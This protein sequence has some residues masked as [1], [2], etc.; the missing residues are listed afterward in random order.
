MSE[1][2]RFARKL[3]PSF[4]SVK[5]LNRP[6]KG[7][8]K[9]QDDFD[10]VRIE[11]VN[12]LNKSINPIK[13]L[14]K[15]K[16]KNITIQDSN[17]KP[18]PSEIGIFSSG[19]MSGNTATSLSSN[20]PEAL[21]AEAIKNN[22]VKLPGYLDLPGKL[23]KN[24]DKGIAGLTP[25]VSTDSG[26]IHDNLDRL[27]NEFC[28]F[29]DFKYH[30]S[31]IGNT[32]LE[33]RVFLR[34]SFEK[35]K[36]VDYPTIKMQQWNEYQNLILEQKKNLLLFQKSRGG[37]QQL[38]D[39]WCQ[40]DEHLFD[41]FVNNNIKLKFDKLKEIK[42]KRLS[43]KRRLY[44]KGYFDITD[45]DD[46][47]QIYD[48]KMLS[49]LGLDNQFI[50][51]SSEDELDNMMDFIEKI[52]SEGRIEYNNYQ[53]RQILSVF[54]KKFKRRCKPDY[55]QFFFGYLDYEKEKKD[56][57]RDLYKLRESERTPKELK[58]KLVDF[59]DKKLNW[60]EIE[61]PWEWERDFA[62]DEMDPLK[63]GAPKIR[64]SDMDSS[65]VKKG[66]PNEF[67]QELTEIRKEYRRELLDNSLRI[68]E[69]EGISKDI[70]DNLSINKEF[71][72]NEIYGSEKNNHYKE[73][74][75][76][77]TEE[78]DNDDITLPWKLKKG[79]IG[80]N[81]SINKMKFKN[82]PEESNERNSDDEQKYKIIIEREDNIGDYNN[83]ENELSSFP[84][85]KIDNYQPIPDSDLNLQLEDDVI[86][87]LSKLI[88]TK[89]ISDEL[90]NDL[91]RHLEKILQH[92]NRSPSDLQPSN[93]KRE[94][95]NQIKSSFG[96]KVFTIKNKPVLSHSKQFTGL[97]N[98][99]ISGV[100]E[101]NKIPN[102]LVD[103]KDASLITRIIKQSEQP[104]RAQFNMDADQIENNLNILRN[105]AGIL[106]VLGELE[107][108]SNLIKN[109]E[110][111]KKMV[112]EKVENN[113]FDLDINE[114][115]TIEDGVEALI[116]DI[117]EKRNIG[118]QKLKSELIEFKP[119]QT[120]ED[121]LI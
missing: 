99:N 25:G 34:N 32:D 33:Q 15:P 105:A 16:Q 114:I 69:M 81:K 36:E 1:Y 73:L 72:K 71:V 21:L 28:R 35:L 51:D 65:L 29:I 100:Q 42:M 62:I 64:L 49:R 6:L 18:T 83:N 104:K 2:Q 107:E 5:L 77:I 19:Q 88:L 112:S 58:L 121:I 115:K 44:L 4:K 108:E 56:K 102:E 61:T 50:N 55:Y 80:K 52:D 43:L 79:L 48:D 90:K 53:I 41:E 12:A 119:D 23:S 109:H 10:S 17:I 106:Q 37:E 47:E 91:T 59:L 3:N 60:T 82:E 66:I 120:D 76:K 92:M 118:K 95:T 78:S 98:I 96:S 94:L 38:D 70:S 116:K 74:I 68:Y 54:D 24:L 13:G 22:R 27:K 8:N 40:T 87:N 31:T 67:L 46:I 26:R 84:D 14:F 39:A 101:K 117:L 63:R 9:N 30:A 7:K 89:G 110:K 103:G 45:F 86:I 93:V 85:Y 20:L 11:E 57:K 97:K 75:Q 111:L 113:E